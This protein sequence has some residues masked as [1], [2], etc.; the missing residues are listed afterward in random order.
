MNKKDLYK[1]I[2]GVGDDLLERSERKH[3]RS[4]KGWLIAAAAVLVLTVTV[5]AV[6]FWP[7]QEDDPQ[8]LEASSQE[9]TSQSPIHLEGSSEAVDTPFTETTEEEKLPAQAGPITLAAYPETFPHPYTLSMTEDR[10]K[11]SEAW[12]NWEAEKAARTFEAGY[13]DSAVP[14]FLESTRVF[15]SGS[16]TEN[17]VYSPMSL[18]MS[19]AMLTEVT[20][21]T[22]RQEI[23]DVLGSPDTESL[24][25]QAQK[26]WKAH[27][28]DDGILLSRLANSFWLNEGVPYKK[29]PLEAL[30][31]RYYA[32][33]FTCPMGTG[34]ADQAM[35][36]WI[37]QQTEGFL[38]EGRPAI[39]TN[40]ST[41]LVL[42]NTL[43]FE[44]RWEMEFD[45]SSTAPGVFHGPE[46]D[47]TC[48]FM[49]G[50]FMVPC[51]EA[52]RY[53]LFGLPLTEDGGTVW[54]FAPKDDMTPDE[55]L[56]E[57]L[58]I[59]QSQESRIIH[60]KMP[61][62]DVQSHLDLRD[63]LQAMGI[64][65][66]FGGGD[67]SPLC[68]ADISL[69]TAAQDV[70]VQADE[71]GIRGAALTELMMEAC[72]PDSDDPVEIVLD[73]PF[74][75]MTLSADQLPLFAGVVNRPA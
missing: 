75:F 27:Y 65:E 63:G 68:D 48:D 58:T 17:R 26:V 71:E 39:E 12:D 51:Y 59:P 41:A 61:K 13:A 60:L 54:F 57:G 40:D 56:A 9:G 37:G 53:Y 35:A 21:G 15:L 42:L 22:T 55:F 16:G 10:E 23:L 62:F 32:S 3:H 4:P 14:F 64:R 69:S 30:A 73:R 49:E 45:P 43:T 33:S 72:E 34:E 20:G 46:G 6:H 66:A 2:G 5:S 29:E 52:E 50:S 36:Q 31:D 74:F 19:L 11:V 67:F 25:P 28:R 24:Q 38:E 8:K 70:R 18:Y 1:S 44:A 7:R 47:I